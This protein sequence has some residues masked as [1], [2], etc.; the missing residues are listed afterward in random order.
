MFQRINISIVAILLIVCTPVVAS[1][2]ITSAGNGDWTSGPT[3]VGGVV[4]TST[5]DVVIAAG[6]TI[7]VNDFNAECNSLSFTGDAAQIKMAANSLLTV[8]GSFTLFSTSHCVFDVQWSSTNAK[9]KFAG[10]NVQI[11]SGWNTLG[12]STSFRDVIIDKTGGYVTTGGNNMRLGIQNSLEIINGKFELAVGDDIEG[13]WA[14]SGNY[15]NQFKPDVIIH[16]G[17]EF[18]L[19]DGSGAHHLRSGYDSGTGVHHKTGIWTVYGW[20][21]FVDTSSN[22]FNVNGVDIEAGGEVEVSTGCAGEL[23][24]GPINVKSGGE[25]ES[26]TTSNVFTSDVVFTLDDGGLYDTHTATTAFPASF[27]NNGTVRYSRDTS[28][29]AVMNM[30]YRHLQI[31]LSGGFNKTWDLTG[32]YTISGDLT[33]DGGANLILTA[34]AP[35]TVTIDGLFDAT[36][37]SVDASDPDVTILLGASASMAEAVGAPV[38][39][40]VRTTRTASQGVNETF[41]GIGFELNAAGGA[42]GATEV[43]R[44]SGVAL[45]VDGYPTIK[46]YFDVTPTNNGGLDATLVFHYDESE[47]NTI[48]ESNLWMYKSRDGGTTWGNLPGT[49]DTG[50]NTVTSLGVDGF[51]RLTLAT[52]GVVPAML[53]AFEAVAVESGIAIAWTVYDAVY[54]EGFS[55]FRKRGDDGQYL[56]LD[57]EIVGTGEFTYKVLDNTAEPGQGYRYRVDVSDETG[58]RTLFETALINA[59]ISKL[60]LHQNHP[61]PF[62]PSTTISYDLPVAGHVNLEIFDAAGHLVTRLVDDV[63]DAGTHREVWRG[64]DSAGNSVASGIYFYRIVFGNGQRITKKMALIQ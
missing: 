41:G 30:D 25:Y 3:W 13:R 39:G 60:T 6:D 52:E 32:D 15:T 63:Q 4:P 45:T 54:L 48:S 16:A 9:I 22:K 8:Y 12:G 19:I 35:Q 38:L 20:A 5:D 56:V 24:F 40:A 21:R 2:Q 7:T 64:I 42:P 33:V 14:T 10:S 26:F 29:Q 11:L 59:R 23:A 53:Q 47:L 36:G 37:G 58:T 18:E 62:N 61:N 1:A 31:S 57:A 34:A 27:N 43:T 50:A 28:D 17:G 44:V 49:V 46:R 55:V 51:S